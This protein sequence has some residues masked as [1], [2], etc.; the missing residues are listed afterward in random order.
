MHFG[1]TLGV[2]WNHFGCILEPLW[3]HF[4]IILV[5][6]LRIQW[7]TVDFDASLT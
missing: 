1:T 5:H 2:F 4:G 3:V 6:F 7:Y